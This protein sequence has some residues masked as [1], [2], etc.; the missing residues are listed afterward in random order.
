MSEQL[1]VTQTG[2]TQAGL[3]DPVQDAQA[4]FR[5]ILAAL[6]EPGRV[7]DV[8]ATVPT[9]GLGIGPAAL[10]VVL[11]LTDGDTPLWIGDSDVGD[12]GVGDRCE[13]LAAHLRFH[14]GA[15]I[16]ADR[17]AAQFALLKGGDWRLDQ[18]NPGTEDFPDHSATLIIEVDALAEG[19]PLTL[20]GPGIPDHRHV[21]VAGL[22]AD[23]SAQWHANHAQFPCGV[24]VILACGAR[25]MGLP[26]TVSLNSS[27]R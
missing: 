20:S 26:R 25:L 7:F 17:G 16:V 2:V 9:S 1:V 4:I 3:A 15:P 22:P 14:T 6:S 21:T 18:F 19:G 23:F 8:T 13:A 12:R 27:G 11:S 24:D 10:A 5:T